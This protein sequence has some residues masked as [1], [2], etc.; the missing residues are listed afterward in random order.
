MRIPSK[1]KRSSHH[2]D[3]K[4]SGVLVPLKKQNPREYLYGKL[5][6]DEFVQK[7]TSEGISGAKIEEVGPG[8]QI[9]DLVRYSYTIAV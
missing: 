2:S 3:T 9:I 4:G 7:L 5:N 1:R 8:S 6:A